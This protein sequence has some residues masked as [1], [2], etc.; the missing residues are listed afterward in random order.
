MNTRE[1]IALV[2]RLDDELRAAKA[3]LATT[4]RAA[5]A[6]LIPVGTVIDTMARRQ[7]TWLRGVKVRSGNA[8]G[9]TRFE[10]AGRL[11]VEVSSSNPSLSQWS[12]DAYPISSTSGKRMSGRSHGANGQ[13]PTVRI[14]AHVCEV[15]HSELS[16]TSYHQF[17][18]DELVK[19]VEAAQ[20]A[21]VDDSSACP[22]CG[23]DGGTQCGAV[24]CEY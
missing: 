21:P 2:E 17:C 7:P 4:L 3:A 13:G 9:A 6:T 5:I 19:V 18:T 15:P 11:S 12:V 22:L 16:G 14:W 1:Q 10:I 20:E 24:G 8:R 23:E